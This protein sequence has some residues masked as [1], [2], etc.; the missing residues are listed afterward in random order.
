MTT[1]S[2]DKEEVRA[3]VRTVAS[4]VVHDDRPRAFFYSSDRPGYPDWHD[5]VDA[6]WAG[7]ATGVPTINGYSSSSPPPWRPLYESAIRVQQEEDRLRRSLQNW[8]DVTGIP[9][10]N[11][12]WIHKGRR[13]PIYVGGRS[14]EPLERSSGQ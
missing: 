10:E 7:L 2:F 11:V 4:W 13:L 9:Q 14:E 3:R 8:M 1:T 12:A 5:H 6:M